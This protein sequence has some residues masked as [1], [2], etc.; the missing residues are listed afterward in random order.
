MVRSTRRKAKT[1]ATPV[2][3]GPSNA[4]ES[5]VLALVQVEE[6][7]HQLAQ[8]ELE[9]AQAVERARAWGASWDRIG[10]VFGIS[11]Q[12]AHSKWSGC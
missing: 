6:L 11:R 7:V 1:A 12:A 2:V 10:R 5:Q 9:L 4:A 8:V 3:R